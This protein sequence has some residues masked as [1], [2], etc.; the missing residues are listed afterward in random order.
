MKDFELPSYDT[1]DKITNQ[2]EMTQQ[3][4]RKYINKIIKVAKSRRIQLKGYKAAI[5]KQFKSGYISA[6]QRQISNKRINDARATLNQYINHYENKVKTMKGSGIRN[7]KQRGGNVIFFNN[8]K[9][10]LKKLELIIGETL[11]GNNSVK[12]RNMGVAIL[13]T[14]LI[15]GD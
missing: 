2:P 5:T 9:Q 14:L 8:P 7:R 12:M 10:L 15:F 6:A 1:V 4:N 13:D 3:K 11:A